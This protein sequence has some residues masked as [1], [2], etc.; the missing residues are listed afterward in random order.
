MQVQLSLFLLL[1]QSEDQDV[2]VSR[3]LDQVG[4]ALFV[5]GH[6]SGDH[7]SNLWKGF[8]QETTIKM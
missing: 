8:L 1:V 3:Q 4:N 6:S 5:K 7:V 2:K